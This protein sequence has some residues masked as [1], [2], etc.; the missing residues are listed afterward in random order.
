MC[1]IYIYSCERKQNKKKA[2]KLKQLRQTLKNNPER[3]A[4]LRSCR[5]CST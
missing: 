5:I 2:G 3:P 4:Q 1:Y